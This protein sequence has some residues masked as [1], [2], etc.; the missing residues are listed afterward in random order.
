[1]T[2]SK[3]R[4]MPTIIGTAV[5]ASVIGALAVLLGILQGTTLQVA[6]LFGV[7]GAIGGLVI[8]MLKPRTKRE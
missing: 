4:I 3:A 2:G 1:M 8:V 7:A 6:L 5:A